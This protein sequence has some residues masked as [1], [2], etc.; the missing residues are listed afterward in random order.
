M[1]FPVIAPADLIANKKASGL[2]K[3]MGNLDALERGDR[4]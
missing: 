3:D 1:T 2:P 4:G